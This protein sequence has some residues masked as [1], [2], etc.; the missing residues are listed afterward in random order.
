MNKPWLLL[1]VFGVGLVINPYLAC[2]N[3]DEEA[4]TY[5]EA[6][7]KAALLGTWQGSAE[8]GGETILFSLTLEQASAKSKTQSV[9]VPGVQPQCGSRSFVKPAAACASLT[10]MPVVGALSSENPGLNGAIDGSLQAYRTLEGARLSIRLEDGP[11]L[12]GTID[13]DALSDG[14][15]LGDAEHSGS[16]SLSRP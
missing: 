16:F 9:G 15:V 4:Y 5:G 1:M 14:Q 6:D 13:G 11:T 8:L 2:S 12:V 10:T 3:Q 7:M